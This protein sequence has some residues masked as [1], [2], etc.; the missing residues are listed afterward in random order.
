MQDRTL[1]PYSERYKFARDELPEFTAKT[2]L[3]SEQYTFKCKTT[4]AAWNIAEA[5][6]IHLCLSKLK[7]NATNFQVEL[8]DTIPTFATF[9]ELA[10][11]LRSRFPVPPEESA[12]Y[13][14]QHK[15]RMQGTDLPKYTS[16][17]NRLTA[18][19]ESGE[20]GRLALLIE[21]FL[22]HLT[23]NLRQLVEQSRPESGWPSLDSLQAATIRVQQTLHLRSEPT[24]S[25][26][27]QGSGG[28][29]AATGNPGASGKQQRKKIRIDGKPWCTTCKI[30]THDTASCWTKG[31]ESKNS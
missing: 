26:S 6:S 1:L 10:Q 14:L 16:G 9:S 25:G 31:K 12:A 15:S 18:R 3:N 28:K 11:R 21:L 13:Q 17:F 30:N 24:G 20:A 19:L 7:G 2:D 23:G 5:D 4:F 22:S 27:S 8:Q 29:R